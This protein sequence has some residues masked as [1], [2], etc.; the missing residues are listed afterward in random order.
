MFHRPPD[1]HWAIRSH[2]A[3]RDRSR[4]CV[5]TV[6]AAAGAVRPSAFRVMGP[7]TPSTWSR[8]AVW[9]FL[10]A[11]RVFLPKDPS[12]AREAPRAFNRRWRILFWLWYGFPRRR[13]T[14]R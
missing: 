14:V 3:A 10:T 12:T 9:N 13:V 11:A 1:S 5:P 4:G 2:I 7:T 6:L 8:F